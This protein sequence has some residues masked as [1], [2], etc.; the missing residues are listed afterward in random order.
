MKR[1]FM[2]S[3]VAAAV[4]LA[5]SATFV[6]RPAVPAAF[7][8]RLTGEE[9]VRIEGVLG[10]MSQEEP[11]PETEPAVGDEDPVVRA[12]ELDRELVRKRWGDTAPLRGGEMHTVSTH[13]LPNGKEVYV[14]TSFP[15]GK[16]RRAKVVY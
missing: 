1:W 7:H 4:L 8:A 15:Q 16:A 13:R 2:V 12:M 3:S 11:E 14:L 9:P 5:V 10:W 6:A